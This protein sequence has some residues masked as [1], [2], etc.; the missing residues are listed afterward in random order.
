MTDKEFKNMF[1]NTSGWVSKT[2]NNGN[3]EWNHYRFYDTSMS[4]KEGTF[5]LKF[6]GIFF[7]IAWILVTLGI[8]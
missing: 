2:D 1:K 3:K 5:W 7:L 8:V 6:I 4:D